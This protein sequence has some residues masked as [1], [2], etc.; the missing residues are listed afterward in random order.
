MALPRRPHII[1]AVAVLAVLVGSGLP[2]ASAQ[3][4]GPVRAEPTG[5]TRYETHDPIAINGDADLADDQPTSP[6]PVGDDDGIRSG[7]GT[8][9][10]PYVI[11][12]W[13][14]PFDEGQSPAIHVQGTTDHLVIRDIVFVP[15]DPSVSGLNVWI[16]GAENVTVRD[17]TLAGAQG[18]SDDNRVPVVLDS[19]H[20]RR[21]TVRNVTVA[22]NGTIAFSDGRQIRLEEVAVRGWAGHISMATGTYEL[23]DIEVHVRPEGRGEGD[24]G[25][26]VSL[27][28]DTDEPDGP[29]RATVH[30]LTVRGARGAGLEAKAARCHLTVTDADVT[31]NHWGARVTHGATASIVSSTF[32]RVGR[33]LGARSGLSFEA[34]GRVAVE[35]VTTRD[36]PNA[37][38]SEGSN[39]TI[40]KASLGSRPVDGRD[41]TLWDIQVQGSCSRCR[42]RNSST[43]SIKNAGTSTV[44]ARWNWWGSTAG[45][46]EGVVE[47]D[48][49]TE[50]WLTE[51]PEGVEPIDRPGSALPGPVAVTAF[52]AIAL[53]GGLV[54]A[55]RHRE[56]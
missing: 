18:P 41:W 47:G 45:P 15:D 2:V 36:Y 43:G 52:T 27:G 28:R 34:A 4:D 21:V 10:D 35:D 53:A 49:R 50:P 40:R 17:L 39:F 5:T 55:F 20:V 23:E 11:A 12:R 30:N 37:L 24:V 19:S 44:D 26:A 51:P 14:I 29:C 1:L 56:R 9:D 38:R 46:P 42:I 33:T 48:V 3:P 54:A 8:E 32:R 22:G 16:Q 31:S 6:L 13:R 25:G 7:S